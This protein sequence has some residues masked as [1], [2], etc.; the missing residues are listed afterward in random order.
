MCPHCW[1][2][3]LSFLTKS[4]ESIFSVKRTVAAITQET[5]L[6][7]ETPCRTDISKG[8]EHLGRDQVEGRLKL[9]W[10]MGLD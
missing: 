7:G 5:T 10:Q 1:G 3:D 9:W 6:Q 8:S 4:T 2:T